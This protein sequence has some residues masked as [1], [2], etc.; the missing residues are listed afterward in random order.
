MKRV[1]FTYSIGY[2]RHKDDMEVND[3][4]PDAEIEELV[5]DAVLEKLDWSWKVNN[6]D[7]C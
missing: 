7:D 1:I 4:T 5:R 3:D 2:G 6:S